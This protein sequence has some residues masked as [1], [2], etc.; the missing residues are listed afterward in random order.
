[1]RTLPK[2]LQLSDWHLIY[3]TYSHGITLST[4]YSKVQQLDDPGESI[5]VI[6]DNKGDVRVCSARGP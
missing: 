1:M 3:S 5:L 2:R 6:R 4:L